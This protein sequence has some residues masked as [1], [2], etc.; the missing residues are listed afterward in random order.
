MQRYALRDDQ[1]AR[2]AGFLPVRKGHVG[3]T[4]PAFRPC[5]AWVRHDA[6]PAGAVPHGRFSAA[7][8]KET[9]KNATSPAG[10]DYPYWE[11]DI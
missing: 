1:W 10:L 5:A 6:R 7:M 2:I 4:A 11:Y 8:K 9:K 3:G